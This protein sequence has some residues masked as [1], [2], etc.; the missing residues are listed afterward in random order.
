MAI[1]KP[2]R[3]TSED[4]ETGTVVVLDALGARKCVRVC[5]IGGL[6]GRIEIE[7]KTYL[8]GDW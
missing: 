4:L 3:N 8:V 6:V 1:V 5:E 2:F 7:G